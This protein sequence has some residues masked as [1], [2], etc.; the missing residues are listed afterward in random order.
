[1]KYD[2]IMFYD[3]LLRIS[4]I[5]FYMIDIFLSDNNSIDLNYIFVFF[6]IYNN[7]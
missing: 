7:M 1:M 3:D 5:F 2:N 4:Q 6:S